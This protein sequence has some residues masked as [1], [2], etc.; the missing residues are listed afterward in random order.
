MNLLLALFMVTFAIAGFA[1]T[2]VKKDVKPTEVV[3]C[4]KKDKSGK[5]PPAPKGVKPTPKK[6]IEDK[7][8]ILPK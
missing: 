2:H 8:I 1:N 3:N 4:V 6:K 5:C 7:K